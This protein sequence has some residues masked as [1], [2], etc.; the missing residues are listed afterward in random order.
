MAF[1][2]VWIPCISLW[3]R[4][5]HTL[6]FVLLI[7]KTK[8]EKDNI[9]IDS[10]RNDACGNHHHLLRGEEIPCG[11]QYNGSRRLHPVFRKHE[12]RRS[13]HSGLSKA[14]C[15]RQFQLQRRRTVCT[16]VLSSA[17]SRPDCKPLCG[18]HRNHPCKGGIPAHV[19]QLCGGGF[20][21]V[22]HDKGPCA[23]ADKPAVVYHRHRE[24]SGDRL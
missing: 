7:K 19:Y 14:F 20:G 16:G 13:G 9:N 10:S 21:A 11:R 8:N 24:Q 3:P 22:C 1:A 5:F 15:R 17:H 12:S 6:P 23:Q 4:N 18:F 2:P